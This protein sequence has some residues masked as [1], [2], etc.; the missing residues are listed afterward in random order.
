MSMPAEHMP[1]ILTLT[2]LLQGYADAPPVL[3][4]GVASDSRLLADGYLFLACQGVSSHGLDYLAEAKAAGASAVAYDASTTHTPED[5]GVPVIAVDKLGAKLGEIASR[6]YGRPSE[7]LGVIGITGTN[8]KTT[9]AWLVLQCARLLGERC[10]YLGTLGHGVDEIEHAEGMTTPA[11]VELHGRLA[12]FVDQG[13]SFAAIEVS[14]H[15]LS[16]GR[17]DGVRFLAAL[18]TNLTRDHLDYH[19]D[20]R[21][22]FESKARLFLES[23][24]EHRIVNLDS[25]Y[26]TQLAARC[27][28]E[29]VTVSTDVDRVADTRQ[30]VFVRA[31]T[32]N[33][34]GS[35][36]VIVSSWGDGRFAL[37]LPGDFNVANAVTVLA[38]MLKLGVPMNAACEVLSEV[39]APP[40]RMQRVDA[41][42]TTVYVDYAHTPDAIEAALR[43]LRAHCRGK[44]WCVF[45][46]GG[47]RDAGKRPQMAGSAERL[48]DSI[49]ITSDNPRTEDP[50]QIIDEIVSGLEQ[51]QLA[52]VIEDRAAAI[53]WAIDQAVET[54]IVLIAGKGHENYQQTGAERRPFSDYAVAEAALAAGAT[55]VEQ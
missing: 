38:L 14:S 51:P 29:V 16:Q 17:V 23:D 48:A 30:H 49:V 7:T 5:I 22:Y 11:A 46:C 34:Q 47:E 44:L 8:G 28:P 37:P 31:V 50:Q 24:T 26:G 32:A 13:A 2:D 52:T 19:A 40:G 54:D 36:V 3:I 43:A 41:T 20:M 45:G 39:H 10:G 27:G 53:A 9:V 25:E 15:A 1:P 18:F 6:F 21:D 42:G 33:D 35:D 12:D 4:H 55:G